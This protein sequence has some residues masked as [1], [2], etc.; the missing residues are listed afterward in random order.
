VKARPATRPLPTPVTLAQAKVSSAGAI[1][2][3]AY[4]INLGR[5]W[6]GHSLTT[7]TDGE[8]ITILNGPNLVHVLDA[9]PTHRYQPAPPDR[10][11]TYRYRHPTQ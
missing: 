2:A 11:R 6:V 10:P 7:I 4:L 1:S 3:G 9:D 5:A 8:H